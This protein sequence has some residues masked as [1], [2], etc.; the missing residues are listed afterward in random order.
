MKRI[1]KTVSFAILKGG[2][3]LRKNDGFGLNELLGTAAALIIAALIIP[4]LKNFASD[5]MLELGRW[6]DTTIAGTIFP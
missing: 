6:W 3:L 5:M 2:I 4:G 1:V